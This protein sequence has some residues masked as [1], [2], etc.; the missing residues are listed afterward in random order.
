MI[1]ARA[2]PARNI[3]NA[4]EEIEK[5]QIMSINSENGIMNLIRR[6]SKTNITAAVMITAA[7][8]IFGSTSSV[9]VSAQE[10]AAES[11]YTEETLEEES[12]YTE[13]SE[14][15]ALEE[16]FGWEKDSTGWWYR[17]SDGTYPKSSW[18]KISGSWYLFNNNG[19]MLTGWQKVSGS[20][21][22]MNSSGKMLTGWQKIDGSWYYLYGSG[23]MATG[24]LKTGDH[25]YYMYGSGKMATGWLKYKNHWYYLSKTSDGHMITDWANIDGKNYYFGTSGEMAVGWRRIG[26]SW[27]YL[28]GSGAMAKG[29]VKSGSDW[30]YLKSDGKM[31]ADEWVD[32]GGYYVDSEG[33]WNSSAY[34]PKAGSLEAYIA[35]SETAKK[36]NQIILVVDHN[37]T[38]WTK[39]NNR[40]SRQ[41]E[42]YCG[43]GRNGM[44]QADKHREGISTTP[45]GSFPIMFAFG[46]ASNPGTEMTY[47]NIT[48]K[49]YWSMERSTYNTWVESSTK[50]S[51]EH[52][53]DYYQYKYA[54]AIGFNQDPIV[55][56]NGSAIFLHC[57]STNTWSTGGC[58][59]V[60]ESVMVKLLKACKDGTY[61][62]IV[63]D[64]ASIANY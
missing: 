48:S 19:Y 34:T 54:M 64:K 63:P 62:I 4:T 56:W 37:L 13:T 21:Y 61:I 32:N 60:E 46:K 38:L 29:W 31:A 6:N 3:R 27:Y 50:I 58:V 17:K 11:I 12:S 10:T 45:T 55:Y 51:G 52:L 41:L 44:I 30:Y 53:T 22:Y 36:T 20:W 7:A 25:W 42:A 59:S 15:V 28:Y 23:K 16:Y 47:R 33:R 26:G 24:W 40:W 35:N 14:S 57:K 49:S 18:M 2:D 5:P 8:I 9:S 1:P 43:Y 39:S